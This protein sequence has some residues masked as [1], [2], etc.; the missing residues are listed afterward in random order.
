MRTIRDVDA[1]ADR[2][3]RTVS[4]RDRSPDDSARV[5]GRTDVNGTG[6]LQTENASVSNDSAE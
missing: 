1:L 4:L 3:P 5:W 6:P 2:R